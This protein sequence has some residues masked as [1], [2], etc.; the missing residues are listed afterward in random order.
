MHYGKY[1]NLLPYSCST[2]SENYPDLTR[3]ERNEIKEQYFKK[4]N[5]EQQRLFNLFKEDL[6]SELLAGR[7]DAEEIWDLALRNIR[8]LRDV[9]LI[10]SYENIYTEVKRLRDNNGEK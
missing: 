9:G 2:V 3:K 1:V 6:F 10:V 4:R 7:T 8:A 5:K